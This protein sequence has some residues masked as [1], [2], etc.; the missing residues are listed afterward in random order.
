MDRSRQVFWIS[1]ILSFLT[2]VLNSSGTVIRSLLMDYGIEYTD[3]YRSILWLLSVLVNLLVIYLGYRLGKSSDLPDEYRTYVKSMGYAWVVSTLIVLVPYLLLD[4][5][6]RMFLQIILL[7]GV[8]GGY[9]VPAA[10]FASI[11]LGW[12]TR[13]GLIFKREFNQTILKPVLVYNG[14]LLLRTIIQRISSLYFMNS[15]NR[16][17]MSWQ[18][19]LLSWVMTPIWLG[20]IST[21]YKNGKNINLETDY[22]NIFYTFWISSIV[23][24]LLT[25]VTN[26]LFYFVR[27]GMQDLFA[28]PIAYNIKLIGPTLKVFGLPFALLC[29]SYIDSKYRHKSYLKLSENPR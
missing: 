14:L 6:T 17:S 15:G 1:L 23:L 2:N 22:G 7:M 3:F 21:L 4:E 19:S 24:S 12:L 8:P 13:D 16:S 27:S 25:F 18:M 28:L 10:L 11:S 5:E 26:V 29:Y 20:Y 9:R